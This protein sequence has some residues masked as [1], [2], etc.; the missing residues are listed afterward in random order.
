[1]SKEPD[2]YDLKYIYELSKS[3]QKVQGLKEEKFLAIIELKNTQYSVFK[4][5][6]PTPKP[7]GDIRIPKI[8]RKQMMTDKELKVKIKNAENDYN[9]KMKDALLERAYKKDRDYIHP[10]IENMNKKDLADLIE[11]GPEYYKAKKQEREPEIKDALKIDMDKIDMRNLKYTIYL[12]YGKNLDDIDK[13]PEPS[14][15]F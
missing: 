12:D 5:P 6:T 10:I 4:K 13:S 11:N 9:V 15:D 8:F 14:D 3:S 7:K 2:D 1:M